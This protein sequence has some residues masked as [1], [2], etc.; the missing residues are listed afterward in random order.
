MPFR[1]S[2]ASDSKMFNQ[3]INDGFTETD[4]RFS[5]RKNT[6]LT[7]NQCNSALYSATLVHEKQDIYGDMALGDEFLNEY[8]SQV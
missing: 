2:V 3:E 8:F 5:Y 4:G 6:L 1:A 7:A